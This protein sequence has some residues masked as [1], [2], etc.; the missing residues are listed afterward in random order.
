VLEKSA[1]AIVASQGAADQLAIIDG[2][3]AQAGVSGKQPFNPVAA[4]SNRANVDTR[5]TLPQCNDSVIVSQYHFSNLC[6]HHPSCQELLFNVGYCGLAAAKKAIAPIANAEFWQRY[7]TAYV[8][9]SIYPPFHFLPPSPAA[10]KLDGINRSAHV[11][12]VRKA[13]ASPRSAVSPLTHPSNEIQ[14]PL[15]PCFL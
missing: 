4:I 10:E 1:A 14:R 2:N 13:H 11:F 12:S 9:H 5:R 8:Q 15:I 6:A 3:N 7:P